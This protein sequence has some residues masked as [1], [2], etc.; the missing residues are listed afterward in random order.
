M[1][2]NI[3]IISSKFSTCNIIGGTT[4]SPT[5][6]YLLNGVVTKPLPNS[7]RRP[8]ILVTLF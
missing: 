1:I 7:L 2:L 8:L 4:S 6:D 5:R 3:K